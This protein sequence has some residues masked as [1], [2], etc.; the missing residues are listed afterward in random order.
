[1]LCFLKSWKKSIKIYVSPAAIGR[2]GYE[3]GTQ[4]NYQFMSCLEIESAY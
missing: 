3:A 4:N 2:L 1:M